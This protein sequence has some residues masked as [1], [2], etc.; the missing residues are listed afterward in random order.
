MR[1]ILAVMRSRRLLVGL[2]AAVAVLAGCGQGDVAATV[3]D[4]TITIDQVQQEVLALDEINAVDLAGS[5]DQ[6]DLQRLLLGRQ[7]YHLLL[8]GLAEDKGIEVTPAQVD[9]LLASLEQQAGGPDEVQAFQ[10]QNSYTDE[11][12]RRG[13]T[14]ALIEQQLGAT[15]EEAAQ[16]ISEHADAV[17]VDVNPRFGSWQGTTL[18][19]GTGSISKAPA[20]PTAAPTPAPT[21]GG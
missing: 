1:T 20:E 6:A 21:P 13:A 8:T 11:G 5:P 17:G 12:L 16:V 14:D 18:E 7:I 19:P 4:Q 15:P 2:V 3:G 9:D 10:L